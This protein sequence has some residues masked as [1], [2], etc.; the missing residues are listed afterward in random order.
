MASYYGQF[1][2]RVNKLC[3]GALEGYMAGKSYTQ[4]PVFIKQYSKKDPLRRLGPAK[5]IAS[6]SLFLASDVAS[7]ITGATIMVEGGWAA[8]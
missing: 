6:T 5:Q 3:P 8:V 2:I 4:N 7:Y 1:N